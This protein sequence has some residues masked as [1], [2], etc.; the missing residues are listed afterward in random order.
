MDN[1]QTAATTK[2]PPRRRPF[3]FAGVL[4]FLLGPAMYFVQ[5]R[6]GHLWMP[7]YVPVLASI[8]VLFMMVSVWQRRGVLR[9]AGLLLFVLLCGF[10]WF[11]ALVATKSPVYT[12][13]AQ[14][15]RQIPA[16]A[17]TLADGKTFTNYDLEN[18][19][20]TVLVF[21]RGRW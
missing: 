13:P 6:L 20:P 11:L 7:W 9:S 4:L 3:F 21:F 12:G 14:P 5:L 1:V 18:G 15:G 2:A 17:A 16:F 10:E 19:I 8:G